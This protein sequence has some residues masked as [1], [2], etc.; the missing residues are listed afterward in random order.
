MTEGS[1]TPTGPDTIVLVQ[2]F[3]VTPRS[4]ER[5]VERYEAKGY[6]VLTPTYPGFE[7][8]VEAL[9]EEPD[10]LQGVRRTLAL[11]RHRGRRLGGGRRLRLGVGRGER[12]APGGLN[13][14]HGRA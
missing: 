6:R 8:E 4:W 9:R 2:G 11:R 13:V 14:A 10:R 12:D 3:W 1:P 5:W 7:G